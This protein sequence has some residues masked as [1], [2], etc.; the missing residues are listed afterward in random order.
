LVYFLFPGGFGNA[1]LRH[2]FLDAGEY[3]FAGF[4][5]SLLLR[6]APMPAVAVHFRAQL[7]HRA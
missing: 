5:F 3:R 6:R 4:F 1:R 2:F 7:A